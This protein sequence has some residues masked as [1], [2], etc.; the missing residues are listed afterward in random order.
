M[1]LSNLWLLKNS[2]FL[3]EDTSKMNILT[4]PYFTSQ[5]QLRNKTSVSIFTAPQPNTITT[6]MVHFPLFLGGW[7]EEG[8]RKLKTY[9]SSHPYFSPTHHSEEKKCSFMFFSILKTIIRF[10]WLRVVHL[11]TIMNFQVPQKLGNFLTI[12]ASTGLKDAVFWVMMP[13]DLVHAFDTSERGVP[14]E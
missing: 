2:Y 6:T 1:H 7:G 14:E 10:N 9:A 12:S 3:M 11:N 8:A 4:L 13:L 5:W